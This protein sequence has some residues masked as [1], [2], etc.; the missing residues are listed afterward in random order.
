ME[1]KTGDIDNKMTHDQ[2]LQ[3]CF[4]TDLEWNNHHP[5]KSRVLGQIT[6]VTRLLEA[7]SKNRIQRVHC[8]FNTQIARPQDRT[9]GALIDKM[10][11]GEAALASPV[12]SFKRNGRSENWH[13]F[14]CLPF[15]WKSK[16]ES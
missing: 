1:E 13:H 16:G 15:A 7:I 14:L 2:M 10:I 6:I 3:S 8:D 5:N 9:T 4:Y 12:F 11:N